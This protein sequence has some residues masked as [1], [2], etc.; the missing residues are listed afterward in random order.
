MARRTIHLPADVNLAHLKRIHD[1]ATALL[2]KYGLA[3][4]GWTAVYDNTKRRGGQCRYAA[5]EVGF[6]VH[7]FAIWTYKAAMNTVLHEIAHALCPNHGHDKVWKAKAIEIGCTGARQYD[8]AA[9]GSYPSQRHARNWV[10][11]CPNGH[12][13]TRARQPLTGRKYSCG[14][15]SPGVFSYAAIITWRKK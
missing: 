11:T 8:G 9:Q 13:Q 4:R 2:D 1:D 14:R 5:K 12:T 7:L 15:C 10:G 3:A 6:S